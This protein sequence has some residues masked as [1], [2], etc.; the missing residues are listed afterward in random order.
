LKSPGGNTIAALQPASASSSFK[1]CHYIAHELASPLTGMLVSIDAIE[2]QLELN[3]RAKDDIED[4]L[5]ILRSETTRL[6]V[7]LK[8]LRSSRVLTDTKAQPTSLAAEITDLLEL[9]SAFCADRRIRVNQDL[10]LDLPLI[11]ADRHKLRQVLLNLC[12]NA[13]EAMPEGGT[14]TF[15]SYAT[16]EWA[17]LDIS[18]TGDGIPEELQVF[19]PGVTTKA[20]SSGIGLTIVR[21]IIKQHGG[22]ISYTSRLRS[23]TTFHL[24]FPIYDESETV[25]L[26]LE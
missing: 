3:L 17:C 4:M 8:E 25:A 14:L 19:E 20:R 16:E 1:F 15:R 13:T 24:K 2:R 11:V 26:G 10:R 22:T 5:R 7:L 9:Q 21:E 18:D 23:G 12:N 6:M